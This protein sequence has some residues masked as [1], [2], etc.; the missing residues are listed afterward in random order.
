MAGGSMVA[1][2]APR[3][4]GGTW[5][6]CDTHN[7]PGR[8]AAARGGLPQGQPGVPWQRDVGR[9]GWTL[10]H[11]TVRGCGEV[12]VG[13]WLL[14]K[15][16]VSESK[17]VLSPLWRCDRRRNNLPHSSLTLLWRVVRCP[18]PAET[19]NPTTSPL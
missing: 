10:A 15:L 17:E 6:G 3:V 19:L 12:S 9:A 5:H 1:H 18:V 11:C 16:I 4:T 13:R 2:G 14:H 8:W 7:H